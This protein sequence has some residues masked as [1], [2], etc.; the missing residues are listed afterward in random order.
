LDSF[1][2]IHGEEVRKELTANL[3]QEDSFTYATC[4]KICLPVVPSQTS[5]DLS[6]QLACSLWVNWYCHC[7]LEYLVFY[8]PDATSPGVQFPHETLV[9][10]EAT[11]NQQRKVVMGMS[12][13][14]AERQQ[15]G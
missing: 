13:T 11:R 7:G 4:L 8:V 10:Y 1:G 9:L 12:M 5:A 2:R 15:C 14:A 6:E 3:G